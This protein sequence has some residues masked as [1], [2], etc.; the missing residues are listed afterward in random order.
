MLK[1]RRAEA[2]WIEKENRWCIQVQANGDRRRFYSTVLGKRGKIEA[3]RKADEWLSLETPKGLANVKTVWDSW[4]AYLKQ[5]KM[6]THQYESIGRNHIVSAI[7][8]KRIDSVT[9][10]DIQ[11][12][13]TRAFEKGLAKKTL[14]NIRGCCSSFLQYCRM[15]KLTN[16]HPEKIKINKKAPKPKKRTMQPNEIKILFS[17]ENT[18]WRGK[19][20]F[21]WYIYTYR[22]IACTGLRPSECFGLKRSDIDLDNKTVTVS[23]GYVGRGHFSDGKTDNAIRT[24]VLNDYAVE[25]VKNQLALLRQN[26]VKCKWMFPDRSGKIAEEKTVWQN[27][28]RYCDFNG[29]PRY[30]VYELRHTYVSVNRY[31]PDALLKL[32]VGHSE[33]MDTRGVY[34]HEIDGDN[35]RA[36]ELSSNAFKD[37]LKK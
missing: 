35:I 19:E 13:V 1:E 23:G 8:K 15:R 16:L 37:I 7:G 2:K 34:G 20:C 4:I 27:F 31:M 24:F 14:E 21:E 30:S 18:V 25:A 6:H 36:A 9:E 17:N 5:E 26:K 29:I 33:K 32:Q 22:F 3:E 12:I 10:F 11:Q 28:Q